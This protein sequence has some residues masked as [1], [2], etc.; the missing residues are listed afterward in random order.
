MNRFSYEFFYNNESEVWE[1]N[2]L[3]NGD[4][5]KPQGVVIGDSRN[6]GLNRI[7]TCGVTLNGTTSMKVQEYTWSNDENIY[8]LN[9]VI[10]EYRNLFQGALGKARND[11]LNNLYLP[12]VT[13]NAIKEYQWK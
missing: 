10:D 7:I 2:K 9:F 6:D 11:G 12:D 1:V 3:D 5:Y 4:F 8:A 13:S